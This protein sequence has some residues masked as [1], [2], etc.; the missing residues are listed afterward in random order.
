VSKPAP[1]VPPR[2]A[3]TTSPDITSPDPTAAGDPAAD[4]EA[5]TPAEVPLNR[6]ERRAKAGKTDPSH[7]GPQSGPAHGGRGARSHTKRQSG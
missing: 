7:V 6:A 3:D 5:D 1:S 2:T 4:L